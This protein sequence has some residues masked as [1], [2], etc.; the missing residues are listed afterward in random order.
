MHGVL[1]A[2]VKP[3]LYQRQY[4]TIRTTLYELIDA[5]SQEVGHGED[6]LVN[7][8]VLDTLDT[9][10]AKFVQNSLDIQDM[11]MYGLNNPQARHR[12]SVGM[13]R[14]AW[15]IEEEDDESKGE[16]KKKR[17]ATRDQGN[18]TPAE[19]GVRPLCARC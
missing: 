17:N 1:Q 9:S 12:H 3:Q 19:S 14:V 15:Q 13:A 2:N 4:S 6:W 8:V 5:I 10:H 11:S 18:I 16:E 7:E